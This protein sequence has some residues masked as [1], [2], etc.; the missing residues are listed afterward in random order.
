MTMKERKLTHEEQ[1]LKQ[2]YKTHRGKVSD[3]WSS[4]LAGYE[5]IFAEY[6]HKP[7]RLLE[8]GVENGGSLEIWSQYFPKARRIVGCDINP[9]CARLSYE[10][11]RIAVVIGDAN[12]DSAQEAILAHAAA[13]DVIIDDGSH[14]SSDII[15]SFARYF[16]HLAHGGV[17]I[18]EDLHCSYSYEYEGGLYDPFS[19]ITF[20]KRLTDTINHEHWGIDKPRHEILSGFFSKYG[21][22]LSE[23][24]LQT[25][26]SVEFM[27]SLCVVRKDKPEYNTLNLR[28]TAGT[29]ET[30]HSGLLELH[31]TPLSSSSQ[32][33]NEW[34]VRSMP[35]DEE[36]PLR[37]KDIANLEA[38]LQEKISQIASL[39]MQLQQ[40]QRSIVMQL[41]NRYQRVV[42]KLLRTGTRRRYYYE[43][44][45]TG[46]R[47]IL[48]EGWRSFFRKAWERLAH[49]T[50]AI[51]KPR[52]DLPKFNASI[53]KKEADKLIFPLP[54][55][56]PEVSIVIPAYNNW[57]YTLN[58]LKSIAKNTDGDYEVFVIDDASTDET[59]EVLP[60]VKN[61]HLVTNKQNAG[62]VE[63]CNRGARASKGKNVLFLN[64]DTMVTKGWLPPLLELIRRE[65]VGAVGSKLV[66][67]DGTLQEAGAIVWN[68][69]TA[70]N[71]GRGDDESKP[72]YNFVREVDYCTGACL[73][74]KKEL[75][76]Q[77]KGFDETF[78]PGYYE[79][80]DLCL[81]IRE[82]GYKVIYQPASVIVHFEGVTCGT[83]MSSGI[84]KY[85][86][87]NQPKF[88]SKWC[89]V[90]EAEHKEPQPGNI[91]SAR[92]RRN[93]KTLL[94][95]DDRVPTSH[96]GAGY[97]RAYK[98]LKFLAELGHKVTLFPLQDS[99]P[100]QPYTLELQQLGI[101]V[102]YGNNLNFAQ[103]AESRS[104]Y[105]ELIMVSRPHNMKATSATIKRLFPRAVILYDAEAIFSMREVLK[106]RVRG[107]E[108]MEKVAERMMNEEL[109]LVKKADLIITVSENERKVI[110]EKTG[111]N[112]VTVWGHPVEVKEPQ[113][114]FNERKD[115]L[116]V[117]GFLGLDSPNED[118]IVY[119]AKE[120]FPKLEG[121]LSCRLFIV[122]MNPPKSVRKL[123]SS[124]VIVTGY[125]EDL[126]EYYE[127]C[128][129]FVV[130]HRYS[131]GIPLKLLEA[132]GYGIPSVVSELTATQLN[133]TDGREVSVAKNT[134]E[135]VEKIMRLYK[136][137]E[138][139]N[140]LQQNAL[141]Y[142][143]QEC[144]P[145][146][147]KTSLKQIIDT[148][149]MEINHAPVLMHKVIKGAV[150]HD[151]Q[152][153]TEI[154]RELEKMGVDVVDFQICVNDF[155][156]YLESA[157]YDT[158]H[159]Y[160]NGGKA[161]NF[162]EKAL[163]HYLAAKLLN[164]SEDDIYID[165][166]SANSPV[167]EIY[168]RLFGCKVYRQD[169]VYP[170]GI[171]GNAIGCDAG[172]MPVGDNFATKIALHCSFE[173]FEQDA[174]IRFIQEAS[175]VLKKGGKVCILPLY[176]FNKYSIQTD[177][178]RWPRDGISFDDDA[179]LYCAEG[180]GERHGR[181]YDVPH[182]KSR[183]INNLKGLQLTVYYILNEKEVAPSCYIKFMA[184]LEKI[185]YE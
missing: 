154:R 138:L 6:R 12:S 120:V 88:V 86:A 116:F 103:F 73:L 107:D 46:I 177:P 128:R 47:V 184:L 160:Y 57:R 159:G 100:W 182:L 49:R 123:S 164:L 109:N 183:V 133:L 76:E 144:N 32:I 24:V 31:L 42:E 93:G 156:D 173:H 180:W 80:T 121:E 110:S 179:V 8:I 126:R 106:A 27:N 114:P 19:S 14:L 17:F 51:R 113:T 147:L 64:N 37:I 81:A 83:D 29:L 54:S 122:G 15:K 40:I 21:F 185:A 79:E 82:M 115:I 39:E 70:L 125:V 152:V 1:T 36:L 5:R 167:P 108:I 165:I 132:M 181:F 118:A 60:K 90:L 150:P 2:L 4:Y 85:Q 34:T 101:E 169:L 66:Y 65:D 45:L 131:A 91:L 137:E 135:F 78:K 50:A 104:N 67:P 176:L 56:K 62:F 26:H 146:T 111:L 174:D 25:V 89:S 141:D 18:V 151:P 10:D 75:F 155:K 170:A 95:V 102:F 30:V 43:L 44:G 48:N 99:T 158:F 13:F 9:D 96:L 52:H 7:V 53:S 58:C 166:A 16:P 143:R 134:T 157:K 61:L 105:Y 168:S 74:V 59:A 68:D 161:S 77:L 98:M 162:I 94:V 130:P 172:N 71:Y 63:S 84:R 20:F 136:D 22:H 171:H 178:R 72:E 140:Q 148:A 38:S 23:E 149:C 92:D 153:H 33:S 41:L 145:E 35:P 3:K 87:V 129:I 28:V 55:H 127:K 163:E 97:P 117:G 69:G 119:F 142:V 139:W 11:T 175:R 112:N 124:S